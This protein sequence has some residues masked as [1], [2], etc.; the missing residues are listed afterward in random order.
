MQG[1]TAFVRSVAC[2]V[3]LALV[4]ACSTTRPVTITGSQSL[5]GQIT[6]G[7]KVEVET[8]DGARL[9]FKVTGVSPEGLRG[10]DH[11][12]PTEDIGHAQVIEGMHPGMVAFLVLLGATAAWMLADPSDVCGDWPAKPC[13]DDL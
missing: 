7:D 10:R 4:N 2:L 9:K 6:V 3:V 13:D 11:F 1:R 8:K 12:V 5:A